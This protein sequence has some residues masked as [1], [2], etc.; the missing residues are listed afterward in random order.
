MVQEGSSAAT[1]SAISRHARNGF[2][3][4]QFSHTLPPPRVSFRPKHGERPPSDTEVFVG[5]KLTAQ[6]IDQ[7]WL[8]GEGTGRGAP[9]GVVRVVDGPV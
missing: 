5:E 3:G 2:V 4:S 1:S 7:V 9:D 8:P 6:L